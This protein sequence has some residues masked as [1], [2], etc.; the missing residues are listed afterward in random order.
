MRFENTQWT[1]LRHSCTESQPHAEPEENIQYKQEFFFKSN[2]IYQ[3][4]YLQHNSVLS[5][6]GAS[7]LNRGESNVR[8]MEVKD[9]KP[10]IQTYLKP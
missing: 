9:V 8:G 3:K 4:K 6:K 2:Q 1:T 7:S 5:T 10:F